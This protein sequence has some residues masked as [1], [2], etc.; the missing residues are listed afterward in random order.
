MNLRGN[1][2]RGTAWH[3]GSSRFCSPL[4]LRIRRGSGRAL[5]RVKSWNGF[6]RTVCRCGWGCNCTSSFGIRRP[7]AF[8]RSEAKEVNEAK[9]VK[10]TERNGSGCS[11]ARKG[12]EKSGGAVERGDGFV[13]EH[14][15]CARTARRVKDSIAPR[16]LRPAHRGARTARVR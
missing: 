14:G 3:G 1:L 4:C 11:G 6:W 7:R 2:H 5:S 8:K 15:D 10:D 9:E 16:Q 13:R 12:S